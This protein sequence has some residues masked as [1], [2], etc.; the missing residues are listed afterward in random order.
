MRNS[1]E[2]A[3]ESECKKLGLKSSGI[4]RITFD[5][6]SFSTS[7]L[8]FI[9]ESA[10]PTFSNLEDYVGKSYKLNRRIFSITRVIDDKHVLGVTQRGKN[11]RLTKDDIA[12]MVEVNF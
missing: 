7:K 10:Q 4:G 5:D 9:L 11:F 1:I 6:K 8:T 2:K 12:K 3:I